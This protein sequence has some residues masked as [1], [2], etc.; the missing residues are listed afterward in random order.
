[1]EGGGEREWRE[2]ERGS[3]REGVGERER[4]GEVGTGVG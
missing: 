3:G 4:G 2:R 1:M